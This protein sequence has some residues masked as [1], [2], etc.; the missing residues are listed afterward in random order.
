MKPS[1]STF[2]FAAAVIGLGGGI[3]CALF[4]DRDNRSATE[5]AP[6]R[7]AN[8]G[9][10]A[11]ATATAFQ[12][13]GPAARP[14]YVEISAEAM[15]RVT[16]NNL[17]HALSW[18]HISLE[19]L[20]E[21]LI[22]MG[23]TKEQRAKIKEIFMVSQQNILELEKSHIRVGEATAN[24]IRLDKS[25]MTE[26]INQLIAGMQD[27]IRG[28]LAGQAAQV[29]ITALDMENQYYP[30]TG[31]A[32]SEQLVIERSKGLGSLVAMQG[33]ELPEQFKELQ[34]KHFGNGGT[35]MAF[36]VSHGSKSGS[37]LNPE[38]YKDDGTPIPADK[39]FD[40]KW[41]SQLKGRTL[42]PKD[43]ELVRMPTPDLESMKEMFRGNPQ[44]EALFDF[45]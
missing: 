22:L 21:S 40:K 14:Q 32:G 45:K 3:A 24:S 34:E 31:Q 29:L 37:S 39:V 2:S 38:E 23:A 4:S 5:S 15:V 43:Q 36:H 35:L 6:F 27:E 28:V 9:G 19:G 8:A 18:E 30:T 10:P 7:P 12:A 1:L 11:R 44:I 33:I 13:S 16:R 25:G 20:D 42:L 17:H 41:S 26:P